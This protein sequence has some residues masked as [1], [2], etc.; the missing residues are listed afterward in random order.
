M[1]TAQPV[2]LN[3]VT[4]ATGTSQITISPTPGNQIQASSFPTVVGGSSTLYSTV[5]FANTGTP[6]SPSNQVVAT[7]N[8]NGGSV[9][10]NST[11]FLNNASTIATN[12]VFVS[13]LITIGQFANYGTLPSISTSNVL[14]GIYVTPVNVTFTDAITN[15][16]F[17]VLVGYQVSGLMPQDET[18]D[19]LTMSF[20]PSSGSSYISSLNPN[21][22]LIQS[23]TDTGFD[24]I[25]SILDLSSSNISDDDNDPGGSITFTCNPGSDNVYSTDNVN[26]AVEF[27]EEN[28]T[29]D[30][31][32][33]SY[34]F[35]SEGDAVGLGFEVNTIGCYVGSV[36]DWQT[37]PT[38]SANASWIT[39][40]VGA[41]GNTI[42]IICSGNSTGADRV[43]VV[44]VFSNL[45]LGNDPDDTIVIN[46]TAQE[47]IYLTAAFQTQNGT[48][49]YT[50]SGESGAEY[51]AEYPTY[52]IGSNTEIP[53]PNIPA[54]GVEDLKIMIN[55]NMTADQPIFDQSDQGAFLVVNGVPSDNP[56]Q[57]A[58]FNINWI[59]FADNNAL[60]LFEEGI[61]VGYYTV[62]C[63]IAPNNDINSRSVTLKAMHPND[64]TAFDIL[65]ITQEGAYDSTTD[66]A[67]FY[68]NSSQDYTGWLDGVTQP[69]NGTVL[70][71]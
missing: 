29:C 55:S 28:I 61:G 27:T 68:Y 56:A 37:S 22:D 20:A 10:A 24:L 3:N 32:Q 12:T 7:I 9:S 30:I 65:V 42:N 46:Q 40:S 71:T 34:T 36:S 5:T 18:N 31:I 66:T 51:G 59:T 21:Y 48:A 1:Y 38:A 47:A 67:E 23:D 53:L 39:A 17:E 13:F 25:N 19:I 69:T 6:N 26:L 35:P 11:I 49:T 15:N 16:P 45:N 50:E 43:G 62:H 44:G 2:T 14:S 41:G 64:S 52:V 54:A 57:L 33:N 58:T 70:T 4:T 63:N 8:W 60:N